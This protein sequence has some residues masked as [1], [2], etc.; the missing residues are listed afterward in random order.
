MAGAAQIKDALIQILNPLAVATVKEAFR[1]E[2]RRLVGPRYQRMQRSPGYVRWGEQRS[3]IYLL[4]RKVRL[5]IPR[6]RNR[7]DNKE[8]PLQAY[9]RLWEPRELGEE[10][11]RRM[12][13]DLS[14]R[15][16]QHCAE[17]M[18]G[19]IGLAPSAVSFGFLATLL[20]L[21]MYF[22]TRLVHTRLVQV[23]LAREAP[24]GA[25]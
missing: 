21:T 2:V 10:S 22:H 7:R 1:Q 24:S 6:I 5:I 14:G 8:V 16:Y 25:A 20:A 15:R 11:V 4:G 18:P 19:L 9:A 12:L 23:G 3:S 13:V 17:A